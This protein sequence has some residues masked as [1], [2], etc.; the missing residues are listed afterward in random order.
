MVRFPMPRAEGV[1][2][3]IDEP[4]LPLEELPIHPDRPWYC[5]V[6]YNQ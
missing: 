6:D 5:G 2:E 4:G 1:A 3:L